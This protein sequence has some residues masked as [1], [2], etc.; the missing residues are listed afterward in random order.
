MLI[1][2]NGSNKSNNI[3]FEIFVIPKKFKNRTI[4][5]V[6]IIGLFITIDYFNDFLKKEIESR[7]YSFK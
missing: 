3:V 5:K 7:L 4:I 2:T 1:K 6:R